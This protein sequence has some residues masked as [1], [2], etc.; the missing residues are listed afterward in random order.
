MLI[1]PGSLANLGFN[2]ALT[3]MPDSTFAFKKAVKPGATSEDFQREII[4]FDSEGPEGMAFMAFTTATGLSRFTDIPWPKGL[5]PKTGAKPS[6]RSNSPLPQAD[7]LV[8]T[9]TVDEGHALSRVLTPGKDSRNDYV[10]YAHNYAAIARKMS[11]GC[12]AVE[13]KRLGAYWTTTI[14]GKKVLIFKSDSHL[15][16]DTNHAIP[17]GNATLPNEDVW[18]QIIKEVQPKL[19]ITTGTAGGIGKQCEV[20]DVVVSPI[21]RFDCDKW[22][23]REPFH[24]ASYQDIKPASKYFAAAKTLFKANAGQLPKDNNRPPGDPSGYGTSLLR[25]DHRLLWLRHLRQ[26]FRPEGFGRRFRNG[27][28]SAGP[29]G[30]ADGRRR[31]PLGCGAQCLRSPDQGRRHHP[32]P[33]KSGRHHLQG[34]WPLEF[35]V[36]CNCLLG[37]DS[38]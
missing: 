2:P 29:G 37:A 30:T 18:Q 25:T 10:P 19:V 15:S 36:Q 26:S 22:L 4:D 33:G 7:V 17:K 23:K 13:A 28:R 21:V 16:Q 24:D 20:G 14:G 5:E 38:C 11:K 34:I 12:P 32:R 27:R 9:W 8:V 1:E 35:R 31:S 3:T 6:G